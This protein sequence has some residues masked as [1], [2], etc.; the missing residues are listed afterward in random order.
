MFVK[1]VR[2]AHVTVYDCVHV[3]YH[4]RPISEDKILTTV[5]INMDVGE[6]SERSVIIDCRDTQVFIMND[7]GDTVERL[8]SPCNPPNSKTK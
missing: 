2:D 3:S 1:I 6:Q 5:Y 4:P 8:V 7:R